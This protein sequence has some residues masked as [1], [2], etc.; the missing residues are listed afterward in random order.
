MAWKQDYAFFLALILL[1]KELSGDVCRYGAGVTYRG[2]TGVTKRNITCQNWDS[3][4]PHIT[5][6][7][8]SLNPQEGLENNFCRNPNRDPAGP[9]CYTS[10]PAVRWEYCNIPMC[11]CR[12][13]EVQNGRICMCKTP[14]E[15][16]FSGPAVC[17]I[18]G[19]HYPNYC[20]FAAVTCQ[21]RI[22]RT[23][24]LGSCGKCSRLKLTHGEGADGEHPKYGLLSFEP[25]VE[26]SG[27]RTIFQS[28]SM[29]K[30]T[31]V[32]QYDLQMHR[33]IIGQL[34]ENGHI[35]LAAFSFS[36]ASWPQDSL[37]GWWIVERSENGTEIWK[38]DV[39]LQLHCFTENAPVVQPRFFWFIIAAIVVSL[40][41]TTTSVVLHTVQKQ[42]GCLW[43]PSVCTLKEEVK[44][45]RTDAETKVNTIANIIG[46]PIELKAEILLIYQKN[47]NIHS[48]LRKI[49]ELT[50]A[51][52]L[53]RDFINQLQSLPPSI[54]EDIHRINVYLKA[55]TSD[56]ESRLGQ[57]LINFNLQT[58][59]SSYEFFTVMLSTTISTST[60]VLAG[61]GAVVAVAVFIVDIV[62]SI[63][64][65][66]QVRDDLE[67]AKSN[68]SDYLSRLKEAEDQLKE[69]SKRVCQTDIDY[70]S[71]VL[72]VLSE[73]LP[74]DPKYK[75]IKQWDE[76]IKS[77]FFINKDTCQHSRVSLSNLK[78]L[79]SIQIKLL[80]FLQVKAQ[81]LQKAIETTEQIKLLHE[82]ILEAVKKQYSVAKIVSVHSELATQKSALILLAE[83]L[84][85]AICYWGHDLENI[86]RNNFSSPLLDIALS[87]SLIKQLVLYV[88]FKFPLGTI[89]KVL[90]EQIKICESKTV[91]LLVALARP[92]LQSYSDQTLPKFQCRDSVP[93]QSRTYK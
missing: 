82:R 10:S 73:K 34:S 35:Y 32:L 77:T 20:A 75:E 18:D 76:Q 81:E 16:G 5:N 48:Y 22:P 27:N 38:E 61:V 39:Y 87:E 57:A 25:T 59:F 1:T 17:D 41:T 19:Q 90:C 67:K 33:W 69:F 55:F 52:S 9:W 74:A 60:A 4:Y 64:K 78:L 21:E 44:K 68:L 54:S 13:W 12:D 50:K 71:T 11:G 8:S 88:Q 43:Y 30:N 86:R 31:F 36:N 3:N 46:D 83:L 92:D 15:C 62:H 7:S 6:Y 91:I 23:R 56:L 2:K 93:V 37:S 66:R 49:S 85:E 29:Y 47:S 24:T 89:Q 51:L 26:T 45:L 79:Q 53:N 80:E 28:L 65:E 14:E 72:K 58:V 84:P 70:L 40:I 63:E 42:K